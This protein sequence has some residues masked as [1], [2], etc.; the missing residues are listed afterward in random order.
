MKPICNGLGYDIDR[1]PAP[2]PGGRTAVGARSRLVENR[3]WFAGAA[4][5]STFIDI[6]VLPKQIQLQSIHKAGN[7]SRTYRRERSCNMDP[8]DRL[9]DDY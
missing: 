7:S 8:C 9:Q 5:R 3:G 1:R 6:Q 2:T 4:H